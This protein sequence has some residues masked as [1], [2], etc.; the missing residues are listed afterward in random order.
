VV[1]EQ[2][3]LFFVEGCDAVAA[4]DHF[5]EDGEGDL[6]Q[7]GD[8]A[9]ERGVDGVGDEDDYGGGPGGFEVEGDETFWR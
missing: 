2:L 4:G 3:E 7:F 5:G 8:V 1:L 6:V 9:E